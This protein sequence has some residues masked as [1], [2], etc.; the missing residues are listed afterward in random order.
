MKIDYSTIALILALVIPGLAAKKSRRMLTAQT[1]EVVGPTTELGELVAS[2]LTV[3]FVLF[4]LVCS[5]SLLLGLFLRH[6]ALFYFEAIDRFDFSLWS[7]SHRSAALAGTMFYICISLAFGFAAGLVSGWFELAH[8]FLRLI[9]L[10]PRLRDGL[11]AI[12]IFSILEERPLSYQLFTGESVKR[13]RDLIF[14]LQ[15]RLRGSGEFITGELAQYAVVKDE[16]PHRL[17][18]LIDA[19]SKIAAEDQYCPMDG[20]RLVIDLADALSVQIS[21]RERDEA[22]DEVS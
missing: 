2:S 18:V 5:A 7:A 15:L 10:N 6:S 13:R 14:F 8:P 3:H 1:F 12:G 16:E 20:D 21:Y 4:I 19:Q 9:E 17:V 22:L 11:Q